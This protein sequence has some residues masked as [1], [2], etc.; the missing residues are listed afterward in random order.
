MA[1]LTETQA[2]A[3][4]YDW[5]F[6][7]RPEQIHP[8]GDWEVWFYRAGRGSGKTRTATEWVRE[9]IEINGTGAIAARTAADVRDTLIEGPSGLLAIFPP[10]QRP[11]YEPSKRKVTFHNGATVHTYSAEEPDQLRG[12][13]YGF[14]L[15]DELA[16]WKYPRETWDNIWYGLR[17]GRTSPHV[18]VA[19]TPRPTPLVKEILADPMTHISTGATYDNR[20]NLNPGYIRRLRRKYEG[21]RLARQEIYGEVIDDDPRALWDRETI[22][23]N[24]VIK[25]PDMVQVK[26]AVDVATTSGEDSDETGIVGGGK[27]I[28]GHGYILEDATCTMAKPEEWAR[29]AVTLYYKLEAD[30]IVAESNQGGEMIATVIHAVDATVPVELVHA[31][32][33]KHTR[34]EPVAAMDAQGRIHHVGI[35]AEMEDQMCQW[36]PGDPQSP[37]RMDARVWLITD[38]FDIS[39]KPLTHEQVVVYD[40][41]ADMGGGLIGGFEGM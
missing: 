31:S 8:V 12:P 19:S 14:A 20:M 28:D 24:R 7:A 3:L 33:G 17:E 39:A 9:Q 5:R 40:A 13:G 21:T 2:E 37:D 41:V 15:C 16:A 25:A 22:A 26:V 30:G 6:W 35:F 32:R 27:G 18:I 34:A 38:L 1:E 29:A 36:V 11:S 4:I 10:H 23:N